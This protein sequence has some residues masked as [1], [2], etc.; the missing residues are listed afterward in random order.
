MIEKVTT[1]DKETIQVIS[2]QNV[3]IKVESLSLSFGGVRALVDI[4]VGVRDKEIRA[5]QNFCQ[6]RK[7]P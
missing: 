7:M 1:P 4:N 5:T 3:R 2:S 6:E